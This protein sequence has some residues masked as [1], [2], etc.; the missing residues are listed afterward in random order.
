MKLNNRGGG[1]TD[2]KLICLLTF[3]SYNCTFEENR[4]RKPQDSS[5]L[6]WSQ[7]RALKAEEKI[8][9]SDADLIKVDPVDP[10][11]FSCPFKD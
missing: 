7:N 10:G 3:F 2:L 11:S 8:M 6:T 1:V 5:S 4:Q 9:N